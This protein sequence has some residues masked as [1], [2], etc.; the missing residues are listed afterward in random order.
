VPPST[1]A[2]HVVTSNT[3]EKQQSTEIATPITSLTP[4]QTSFGNPNYELVFV[5][6]LSPILPEEMPPSDFFFSKKWKAIVKRESYHK[7]G[8]IIKRQRLVYDRND[9]DG[10]VFAKRVVGS[11]GD[12]ATANQW[13]V[14][15]LTEQ[16][17]Q[18]CIL[19]EH[20][21]NHIC[22]VDQT[23]RDRMSQDFKQIMAYDRH[24]IQ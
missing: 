3:I 16:L 22:T 13:S 2:T 11:L 9:Q 19:V 12:F 14:D 4:L 24:Q 15:N 6:D 17:Q 18:K 21:Q 10:P 8:V 1:P 5:G 23:T 20:L 7:D